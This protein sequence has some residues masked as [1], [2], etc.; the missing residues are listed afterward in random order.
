M[1]RLQINQNQF[2]LLDDD[3]FEKFS[4]W[5]WQVNNSGY[6]RRTLK[7]RMFKLPQTTIYLHRVMMEPPKGMVVDHI[8][9][10]KLDNRRQNLRVVTQQQNQWNRHK[11]NRNNKSGYTGVTWAK[12]NKNWLARIKVNGKQ[13]CLGSHYNIEDAVKARQE[14]ERRY[15]GSA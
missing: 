5:S 6:V 11:T 13:M 3:D 8:N 2:V 1:Q 15:Y 10:D 12:Y 14:V 4:K 9:G 7:R